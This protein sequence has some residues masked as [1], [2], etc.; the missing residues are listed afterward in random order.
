M[1]YPGDYGFLDEDGCLYLQGR[2]SELIIRGGINVYAPEVESALTAHPAVVDAAVIGIPDEANDEE[3]VAFLVCSGEL[4]DRALRAHCRK[5]LSSYKIPGRFERL[6][7]L[8]RSDTGKVLKR[9]LA[10]R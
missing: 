9:L 4:D 2:R 1:H 3:I 8:P 6:E 10:N 5:L 7:A